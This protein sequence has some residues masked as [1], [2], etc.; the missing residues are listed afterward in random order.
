MGTVQLMRV[1][2]DLD[3]VNCSVP[4]P[5]PAEGYPGMIVAVD[6]STP[7]EVAVTWMKPI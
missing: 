4:I 3:D 7:G 1:V 2:Y 6:W 5:K